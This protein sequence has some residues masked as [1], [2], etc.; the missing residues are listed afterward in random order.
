M[1]DAAAVCA[2]VEAEKPG[3]DPQGKYRKMG[4]KNPKLFVKINKTE[5]VA[6]CKIMQINK[7]ERERGLFV[8]NAL[9]KGYD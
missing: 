3:R 2:T 9:T 8:E 5:S 4:E 1:L 6:F 7:I